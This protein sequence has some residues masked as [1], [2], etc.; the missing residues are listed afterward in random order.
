MSK[1]PTI[2]IDPE[3]MAR[4][5]LELWKNFKNQGP[6]DKGDEGLTTPEYAKLWGIPKSTAGKRIRKMVEQGLMIKGRAYRKWKGGYWQRKDVYRPSQGGPG[7]KE[8]A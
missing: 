8:E 1:L 7:G 6:A 4:L 5:G 3:E 2:E